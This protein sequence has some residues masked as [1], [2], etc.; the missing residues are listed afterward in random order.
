MRYA[1]IVDDSTK[2]GRGLLDVARSLERFY[3]SVIVEK[4]T[5]KISSK[6]YRPSKQTV[7][8]V[9]DAMHGK[10]ERVD[11]VDDFFNSI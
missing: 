10:T 6:D 9:N 7:L 4:W 11:D 1:I 5:G 3:K 8:A 2:V